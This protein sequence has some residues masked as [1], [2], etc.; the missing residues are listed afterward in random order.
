MKN[1]MLIASTAFML[2]GFS[3]S[4]ATT[5]V[6]MG[7]N[8]EQLSST[9]LRACQQ[10]VAQVRET[11]NAVG[12][13]DWHFIVICD[14]AGWR[15]YAAFST[16]SASVLAHESA[17]SNIALHTTFLRGSRLSGSEGAKI[18]VATMQDIL[19]RSRTQP[20]LASLSQ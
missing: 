9:S 15:D 8:I 13:P 4:A 18:L 1:L 6:C 5:E 16:T 19:H 2:L 20:E 12:T 17:D 14:D 7:G 3:A 11:A 10:E